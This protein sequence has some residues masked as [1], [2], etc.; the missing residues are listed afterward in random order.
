MEASNLQIYWHE[1]QPIYSLSFQSKPLQKEQTTRLVTA[2]GDNKIRVWQLNF[3]GQDRSKVDTIDFLS[4]LTQHEQAVNVVRF[5]PS[6]E[7]IASAG[8]DGQLLLWRKNENIS[9]EFGVDDEEFA[10][11]K[12]S[13]YVWKRLRSSTA[14]G[15]SEIYDL[16]WSPDGKFVATGSMDNSIRIFDV[17]GESCVAIASDHNHYVQGVVWDPQNEFIFSQSADRSV[18]VH[19]IIYDASGTVSDLKLTNRIIRGDL[20]CRTAAN[21]TE[22]DYKNIKSSYLFHNET[23]PSFFRRLDMSPCG[24]LLCLP[25]GVF[26]NCNSTSESGN[27]NDELANAVYIFTRPYL[28]NSSNRPI[29]VLP[30]FKKP[31]LVVSFCPQLYQLSVGSSPYVQLPY[32]LIFAVA[33]SD[34]VFI[35]DTEVI[36]PICII[37]NLHYTPIT[38]IAWQRDGS[39]VMVSSTDGFCS[40]ISIPDGTLGAVYIEKTPNTSFKPMQTESKVSGRTP[41]TISTLQVR[42]KEK[43]I[44]ED[45]KNLPDA[46]SIGGSPKQDGAAAIQNKPPTQN[47]TRPVPRRI[48]PT[49]MFQSNKK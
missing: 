35:Y 26:K 25:A 20:P 39:M 10:D 24:N 34:E 21:S 9:K 29:L 27:G 16:S 13:W 14:A 30:F 40:Y 8:D 36:E 1:S 18:H 43:P 48:Q 5:D 44:T 19:R 7:S 6:H 31:A 38:D 23:L 22:L 37:G 41:V 49:L 12:E 3:D 32:K 42:R 46:S 47:D 2:G 45:V 17:A 28:K 4:S 11:F 33:T 15:S